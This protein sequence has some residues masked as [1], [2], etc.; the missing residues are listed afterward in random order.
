MNRSTPNNP[1]PLQQFSEA[2]DSD[3]LDLTQ[4]ALLIGLSEYPNLDIELERQSLDSLASGASHRL[5]DE[6]DFL[7]RANMLSEYLFDEVGFSANQEDYYDPRNSYLN[8]VLERRLGIPITLSLLYMEV[9]KRLDMDLEGVGMPGHFLVRVKSG[10]E[11]ILVDPFHRGILLSEQEC[12]SRLQKIAGDTVAWDKRY[13]AGVSGREL[14]T[15]ILRNLR[16]IYAAA[17]DYERVSRV[18]EWIN[19]L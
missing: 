17:N 13:V 12:A 10:Q 2:A 19:A 5:D 15:R 18:D 6:D 9:G 3:D 11:D 16:A 14:I 4:M 8:E 7:A 1:S